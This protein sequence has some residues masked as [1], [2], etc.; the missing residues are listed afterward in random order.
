M[1]LLLLFA[2]TVVMRC[3]CLLL[4]LLLVTVVVRRYCL[5]LLVTAVTAVV[6]GTIVDFILSPSWS[7]LQTLKK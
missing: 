5:L 6:V 7:A 4:L 1:L 3:Y 2:V